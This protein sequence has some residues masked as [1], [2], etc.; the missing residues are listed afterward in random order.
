MALITIDRVSR[1]FEDPKRGKPVVA[2][3]EVSVSV[4][5]NEF[6]CLLGPSG[7]GKSTLLN[8]IAGFDHP[9]SGTVS[10]GGQV[11]TRPGALIIIDNV[12]RNGEVADETSQDGSVQ[13][14][15]AV[16][17]AIAA[18]PELTA[19]ALQTVGVKGWDGLIV[20]RRS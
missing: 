13:G 19:T 4:A 16:V 12:V 6:L 2:L 3:D 18:N 15:R 5:R 7:C 10:V 8:M 14:V 17:D 20:A 9:T 1:L 11:V